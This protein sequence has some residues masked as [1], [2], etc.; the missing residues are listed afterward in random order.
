M[1]ARTAVVNSSQTRTRATML[2]LTSHYWATNAKHPRHAPRPPAPGGL[3][4]RPQTAG[5][6]P[7]ARRTR[8]RTGDGPRVGLLAGTGAWGAGS[9]GKPPRLAHPPPPP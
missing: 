3:A 1:L 4:G 8:G 7:G 9:R 5:R 6:V 2:A